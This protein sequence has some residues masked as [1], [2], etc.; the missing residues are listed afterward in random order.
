MS[1]S[2]FSPDALRTLIRAGAWIDRPD[3]KKAAVHLLTF[4]KL[5]EQPG[6]AELVEVVQIPEYDDGHDIQVAVIRDWPA[7]LALPAV[8]QLSDDDQR[9]VALAGSLATGQPVDL[10]ANAAVKGHE[11]AAKV[12]EAMVIAAGYHL[13]YTVNPTERLTTRFA[14]A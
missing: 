3:T 1:T 5:P 11:H 10:A 9:L 2:E 14:K 8:E 13:K 6:F 7:L 4:T 12:A